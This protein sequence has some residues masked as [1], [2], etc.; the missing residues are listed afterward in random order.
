VPLG[1]A[2]TAYPS[3]SSR[4]QVYSLQFLLILYLYFSFQYTFLL[5]ITVAETESDT[6]KT[7]HVSWSV[8]IYNKYLSSHM[9]IL[10][11][12]RFPPPIKLTATI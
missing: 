4:L 12:L 1:G 8:T 5:L 11:V 3:G 9:H 2:G 7:I 6:R 10:R